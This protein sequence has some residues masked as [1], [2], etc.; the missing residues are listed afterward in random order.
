MRDLESPPH[1]ALRT[2]SGVGRPVAA[3]VA[4]L[5]AP[6]THEGSSEMLLSEQSWGEPG[7]SGS[8]GLVR[9]GFLEGAILSL[10]CGG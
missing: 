9:E 10:Y 5:R 8:L 2:A 1:T 4:I 7:A 6:G 3:P